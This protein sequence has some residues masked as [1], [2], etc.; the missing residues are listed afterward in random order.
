MIENDE[1]ISEYIDFPRTFEKY[2]WYK[3]ILVLIV[4]LIIFLIFQVLLVLFFNAIYGWNFIM[5]IATGGYEV[6]NT[7]VGQ[8]FTDL[9]VIVTIPAL[10]FATKIVKDRPF[11]SYASS[12]G[13]WNFKLYFKA[14]LIP[15]ILFIIIEAIDVVF[16]GSNGTNHFTIPFF[17]LCLILVP[18]QC[19]AEEY[20]FRGLFMQ[21]F[22]SWFKIPILAIILQAVIFAAV[23]GYNSLG[24]IAVFISGIVFGFFTW[25]TNGIEVSS[26][27]HTA[28]NL[29][30]CLF[31]MFGLHSTSSTLEL[32]DT[33]ISV[34][35]EIILLIIMY[36]VGKK[37][38]WFGE[39]K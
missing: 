11:S 32:N 1:K 8:I 24:I 5:Q 26:A 16:R 35:F 6:L 15:F 38:D 3:P 27:I 2:R 19:I 29:S 23:H 13:G 20:I 34:V 30:I 17:I 36:Y 21:T 18:L 22:G 14:L 37:T 10:Y 4:G 25:K 9:G 31:V 33:I 12:R 28:N 39:I 7:E